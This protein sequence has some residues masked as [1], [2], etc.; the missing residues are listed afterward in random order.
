MCVSAYVGFRI[1]G[2][3]GTEAPTTKDAT[4]ATEN[5]KTILNS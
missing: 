4:N 5:A 1:W 2:F 3:G